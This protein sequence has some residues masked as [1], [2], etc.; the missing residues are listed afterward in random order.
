MEKTPIKSYRDLQVWQMAMDMTDEIFD[1][2]T[3]LPKDERFELRS[4][5]NRAAISVPS[6]IAEGWGRTTKTYIYH[7]TVAYGSLMEIETQVLI[8][9]RRKYLTQERTAKFWEYSSRTGQMLNRLMQSLERGPG[10]EPGT[11]VAPSP[12]TPRL[13]SRFPLTPKE[14]SKLRFADIACGSGSFLIAVYDTVLHHVEKWYNDHPDDARKAKCTEIEKGIFAL[15]LKQKQQILLDNIFGVDIDRQAVEVAQ[16]SLFLKLLESESGATVRRGG[17]LSFERTKILPD[18][19]KNIQC[20]NSLVEYDISD[21]FPLTDEEEKKIK[22]FSFQQTFKEIMRDGGFDAIVGNPPWVDLKGM[23]PMRVRYY[24]AHYSSTSNRMNEYATFMERSFGLL[25]D[26]GMFGMI[27][28]SSYLTQSSYSKLRDIILGQFGID[29]IIRTPDNTFQHV[30][31]ESAI[32]ILSKLKSGDETEVVVFPARAMLKSIDTEYALRTTRISQSRWQ[33]D[34]H[35]AF[36]LFLDPKKDLIMEKIGKSG[37]RLE[38]F[39]EFCLGLTP[40]DKY[41]GQSQT[42]IKERQYHSSSKIGK[43]W[44]P[45]LEGADITRYGVKWGGKEYIKYGTW[46]GAPREQR[47]F[48]EPRILVRQ[49]IS[50][51]PLRI[52]A[53]CAEEELYNAQI[54]FNLLKRPERKESLFYL[55]AILNSVLLTWYHR[56]KYLDP[57]KNTFQKILIQDAKDFPIPSID[58]SNEIQSGL[59]DAIVKLVNQMLAAKKQLSATQ[60]DSEKEQLQRKCD[61]IDGEIDR[62]VYELY[63]LTAEEIKIVEGK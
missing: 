30:I 61:Y 56:N 9:T 6:N 21:L 12:R 44:K 58:F 11:G 45:L 1:L 14:I 36:N 3:L 39:C 28:P 37:T 40:Y 50:G 57:G 52:Y 38:E 47:F 42:L 29:T 32:I 59:H 24:F 22:P 60:R 54:G 55:L 26:N 5:M 27:T 4:Q 2:L 17:Q 23:D 8:A 46:L 35:S 10:S 51:N 15:S 25:N 34:E 63:G 33:Q 41:K 31:A 53:G 13:S 48:T 19:S 7:L 16:L 43:E 20:G 49:I 18:L 62:L